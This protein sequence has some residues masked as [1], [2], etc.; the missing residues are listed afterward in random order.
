MIKIGKIAVG[1]SVFAY[2]VDY[3]RCGRNRIKELIL[4][5]ANTRVYQSRGRVIVPPADNDTK[6][7]VR[8]L[9]LHYN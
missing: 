7:A 6:K 3:R 9:Q 1:K 5:R 2:A 8:T 4:E